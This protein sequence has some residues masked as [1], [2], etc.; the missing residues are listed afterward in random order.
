VKSFLHVTDHAEIWSNTTPVFVASLF[1]QLQW[2]SHHQVHSKFESVSVW[3]PVKIHWISKTLTDS[4]LECEE[5]S[6]SRL[7]FVSLGGV[8]N[9]EKCS[10][11]RYTSQSAPF[12][13]D[14]TQHYQFRSQNDW[15]MTPKHS[16]LARVE[17]NNGLM[18]HPSSIW[19][20]L[21]STK[22]SVS[23]AIGSTHTQ[24]TFGGLSLYFQK[25]KV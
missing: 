3:D 12:E 6:T 15:L 18:G 1:L 10:S 16:D 21:L 19:N 14:R 4:N 20:L 22:S 17:R 2:R 23:N 11:S 25:K 9:T 7:S 24:T 13:Q 5:L 8:H